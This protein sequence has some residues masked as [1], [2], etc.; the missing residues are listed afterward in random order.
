MPLTLTRTT[1][2]AAE[3]ILWDEAMVHLHLD[4]EDEKNLVEALIVAARNNCESYT[5]RQFITATWE[6]KLDGFPD[7]AC[8]IELPRP[9]IAAVSSIVYLDEDGVSQTLSTSAY[10][11]DVKSQP[12]RIMVAPEQ[13]WPVTESGRMNPVT[14]TYTAGYG[15]AGTAVPRAIRQAMLLLVAEWFENREAVVVGTIVNK[16]PFAVEALL[17]PYRVMTLR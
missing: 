13:Y 6:L 9:P 2:A 4:T 16:L 11:T 15:A 3:P 7:E 17:N 8:A 5:H 14:V 1:D 12:G 10:Q